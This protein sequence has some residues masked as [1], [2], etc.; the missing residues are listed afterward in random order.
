MDNVIRQVSLWAGSGPEYT[1][2]TIEA[3]VK[4]AVKLNV[5]HIVVASSSGNTAVQL[6]DAI[7][8][9][10]IQTDVKRPELCCV[11]HSLGFAE[12]GKD[13]MSSVM[14]TK[15][16]SRGVRLL[17]STHLMG[18]IERAVSGKF[19]G[20]YPSGIVSQSFRMFGHGTK[21]AVECATMCLD[22]GLVPYG[23]DV[24]AIGGTEQGCDTAILFRP[25][26][27]SR[28]FDGKVREIIC[29]P[30]DF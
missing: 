30:R 5:S 26:H 21:V 23:E 12:N 28:F 13:E 18:G 7:N 1:T 22:A 8:E 16:E 14:R 3:A 11:T 25:A 24:I 17:T 20:L 4:R 10:Y 19:G 9:A 2:M 15:L 6:D 29:K 27:A